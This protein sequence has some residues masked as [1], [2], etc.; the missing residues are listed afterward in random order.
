MYH[1]TTLKTPENDTV[2]CSIVY[3]IQLFDNIGPK[4]AVRCIINTQIPSKWLTP[5]YNNKKALKELQNLFKIAPLEEYGNPTVYQTYTALNS[6]CQKMDQCVLKFADH[7]F[8]PYSFDAIKYYLSVPMCLIHPVPNSI[9]NSIV[10]WTEAPLTFSESYTIKLISPDKWE[11]IS[12]YLL[13]Y[14]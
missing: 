8:D 9:Y 3:G 4:G 11:I 7:Q 2:G 12:H 13:H 10:H 6:V 1:W 5:I 14:H